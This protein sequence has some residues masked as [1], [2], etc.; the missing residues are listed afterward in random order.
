[1]PSTTFADIPVVDVSAIRGTT[2]ER[3]ELAGRLEI[4]CHRIGFF[5]AVGHGVDRSVVDSVFDLMHRFFSLPAGRKLLIDKR[6]SPHF[7]GWEAEGSEYTNNRPDIREQIDAWSE[8]DTPDSESGPTYLRLL[9]PNQ[10]MPEGVLP[11]HREVTLEWMR[12]CGALSDQLL[13]LLALGLGLEE[14]HFARFFGSQP[15]SLTKFIHY[16]PTPPGQAGVNAHHD[17][18]FLTVLAPGPTPGLQVQ[19]PD[20]GWIDVPT[21]ANGFVINLGEMLQGMT[22]NYFVATPHRVIATEKRFSAGYFHGPSLD[23]ALDALPL[24]DRFAD[25]VA[26]S[27]HHAAAGFMARR[28]ETVAGIGDMESDHKPAVYGEQLWNYFERSYPENMA[29][30]Y[31]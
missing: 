25:A 9:G 23:A 17:T 5:V 16:P 28:Q 15:M 8:W 10:W 22:G 18:G 1:M 6:R 11:G 12:Q 14:H 29:L 24:A 4:I 2:R 31:G 30:H 26:A 13:A 21:V 7:R 3:T 20:G 19:N 27:P